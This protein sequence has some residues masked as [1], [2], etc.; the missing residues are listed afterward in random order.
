MFFS[1]WLFLSYKKINRTAWQAIRQSRSYE[2]YGFSCYDS[3][4]QGLVTVR[5]MFS[6]GPAEKIQAIFPLRRWPLSPA[7][8]AWPCRRVLMDTAPLSVSDSIS[9]ILPPNAGFVNQKVF[10]GHTSV[11][12]VQ[13]ICAGIC[14]G[15]PKSNGKATDFVHK[16]FRILIAKKVV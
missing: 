15:L 4:S 5:Q 16:K 9:C 11:R 6:D 13:T 8:A 7:A 14:S 3:A 12:R 2:R 10:T 1:W